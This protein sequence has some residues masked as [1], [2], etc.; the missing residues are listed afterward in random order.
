MAE[1]SR[2]PSPLVSQMMVVP[3]TQFMW[4]LNYDAWTKLNR[5][6]PPRIITLHVEIQAPILRYDFVWYAHHILA[7]TLSYQISNRDWG[8]DQSV[9]DR[10]TF[11]RLMQLHHSTSSCVI[12]SFY[13]SQRYKYNT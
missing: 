7:H 10:N 2:S 5:S 3:D 11:V 4:Y 6:L 8:T 9:C 13:S 12:M 1:W